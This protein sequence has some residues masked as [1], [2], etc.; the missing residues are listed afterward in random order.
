MA[1]KIRLP[2][3]A[4]DTPCALPSDAE[5]DEAPDI[6]NY[7]R[8]KRLVVVGQY[9]VVKYGSDIDLLEGE[10]M[11]FASE[12]TGV[13]VPRVYALY[14]ITPESGKASHYIVMERIHGQN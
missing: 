3:F 7:H 10:N 11:L 6:L 12:H 1:T 13:R 5:I 14:T 2:Y 9:Y 4:A 8:D